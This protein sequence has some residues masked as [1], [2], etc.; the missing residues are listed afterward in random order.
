MGIPHGYS[1]LF[2][3]GGAGQ[4]LGEAAILS[5]LLKS[6][7]ASCKSVQVVKEIYTIYI[8]NYF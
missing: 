8:F 3:I 4:P 5:K 2:F 1:I 7:V 6:E